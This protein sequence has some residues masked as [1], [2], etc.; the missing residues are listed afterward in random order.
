MSQPV[1]VAATS[2]SLSRYLPKIKK[3]PISFL[4]C[5]RD[6][7]MRRVSERARLSSFTLKEEEWWWVVEKGPRFFKVESEE[8]EEMA[9][10]TKLFL[11]LSLS[12]S[13]FLPFQLP[14]SLSFGERRRWKE[15]I[16]PPLSFASQPSLERVGGEAGDS[17][18]PPRP[19]HS[20]GPPILPLQRTRRSAWQ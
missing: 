8:E 9:A 3:D 18:P 14:R 13:L 15:G 5:T 2:R 19:S 10:G 20:L 1:R 11:S 16:L 7:I 4:F 17:P 6:F 12:L